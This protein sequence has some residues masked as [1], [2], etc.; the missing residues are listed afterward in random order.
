MVSDLSS[1]RIKLKRLH[2][3]KK[4]PSK[5]T[6]PDKNKKLP[7]KHYPKLTKIRQPIRE[8]ANAAV[9]TL[10]DLINNH[11]DI[12]PSDIKLPVTLYNGNTT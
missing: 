3:F 8:I 1:D 10:L 11:N 7:N 9:S 12:I 4:K 2:S 5:T 6:A